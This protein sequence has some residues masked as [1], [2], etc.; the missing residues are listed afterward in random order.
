ML[1]YLFRFLVVCL[2]C[3]LCGPLFPS[4]AMAAV[5]PYDP[6]AVGIPQGYVGFQGSYDYPIDNPPP[7]QDGYPWTKVLNGKPI[8]QE[9]ALQYMEVVKNYIAEDMI[10]LLSDTGK[11]GESSN[12]NPDQRGWYNEP[13]LSSIRGGIH[14]VYTGSTC[15]S[16]I[17][18]P[19]SNLKE[20]FTTYVYVLYDKVAGTSLENVWGASDGIFPSFANNAAQFPEGS[21]IVKAALSTAM[22]DEWE[23]MT[24]ALSWDIYTEP[25]DCKSGQQE[26]KAK[27]FPVN[28]FQFDII[29]KDSIAEPKTGWVF[30]TLTYDKDVAVESKTVEN[31]WNDQMVFLGAMWGNDPD[32][33]DPTAPLSETWINPDAPIYAKE[34]L[35]WGGRLSGPNDGAV[36][37]PP[38][39]T[40]SGAGCDPAKPCQGKTCDYVPVSGPNLAMSSCMSCHS[41][42]QYVMKSFLLPEPLHAVASNGTPIPALIPVNRSE[43][44]RCY[45]SKANQDC[46]Q[47]FYDQGSQAWMTWFQDLSG[48]EPKDTGVTSAADYDMNFPFKSLGYWAQNVCLN[49]SSPPSECSILK[50][51]VQSFGLRLE[52]NFEVDYQGRAITTKLDDDFQVDYENFEVDYQGRIIPTKK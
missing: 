45:D 34:T 52:N 10:S 24:G 25:F 26:K 30:S 13:W 20:P 41:T 42:A 40:C 16:P 32:V 27:V 17:L 47:V 7:P 2:L 15:F 6:P 22:E 14:G 48:D 36:Q 28:F 43:R 37:N 44:N 1:S 4:E 18:F 39:A 3:A 19:K 9:T 51:Q 33:V 23:P 5:G 29:V 50:Q 46:Q 21:I 31:I 8:S 12:W 11:Q 35:G 38:Y 49:N